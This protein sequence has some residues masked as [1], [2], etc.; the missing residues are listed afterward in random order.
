MVTIATMLNLVYVTCNR[1]FTMQLQCAKNIH[2]KI[3]ADNYL[4]VFSIM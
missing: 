4:C 1:M 3:Y 2:Y